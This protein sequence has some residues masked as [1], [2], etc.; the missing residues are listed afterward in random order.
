MSGRRWNRRGAISLAIGAAG[1]QGAG[2]G[3]GLDEAASLQGAAPSVIALTLTRQD[4][5]GADW[6]VRS[7]LRLS[8]QEARVYLPE[9]LGVLTDPMRV[10]LWADA[11]A[12]DVSLAREFPAGKGWTWSYAAGLGVQ[13]TAARA[14]LRSALIELA[15]RVDLTRP[16]VVVSGRVDH[17][18][19]AGIAGQVVMFQGGGP[20]F[21][22]GFVQSF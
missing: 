18:T 3:F 7:A 14:H 9:G 1:P 11:V 17:V 2:G 22:L 10:S 4:D 6:Q 5:L 16:Y 21:R 8:R 13:Q 19:G 12:L 20:E 15:S